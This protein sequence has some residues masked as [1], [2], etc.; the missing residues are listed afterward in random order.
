MSVFNTNH[1]K[2]YKASMAMSDGASISVNTIN[3]TSFSELLGSGTNG[4]TYAFHSA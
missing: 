4:P 2:N 1:V 3:I